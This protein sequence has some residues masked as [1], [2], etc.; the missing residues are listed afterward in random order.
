[1]TDLEDAW[2][3]FLKSGEV[4]LPRNDEIVSSVNENQ[5]P[6]ASELYIS[7][8]TKIL[9]LNT[10]IDLNYVFW[11]IDIIPYNTKTNGV[12]KKQMKFI[13]NSKSELDNIQQKLQSCNYY[14]EYI[15]QHLEQQQGNN[16]LYKDSRKISIGVCNKD[17]TNERSKPKSA[18]YNCFVIILRL[19]YNGVFKEIHIKIFN[20]GKVE[21]PGV[22]N[23][24]V[25][26]QSISIL[27]N[28]LSNI[29][30][31]DIYY[32]K[33]NVET[34]LIN[35]NFHCGF[36]INRPKLFDILKHKHNFNVSY[37]PC[38]YPG[39]QCKYILENNITISFMI[40]RTGSILI[41]G[42]CEEDTIRTVYDIIKVILKDEYYDIHENYD[43]SN[44][45]KQ[46]NKKRKTKTIY[47]S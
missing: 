41:V 16:I 22:Q 45:N 40:F 7:T 44:K 15:I 25:F 19:L 17:L 20:T 43:I 32:D 21:I 1:M 8:K 23:D 26:Y 5:P 47:L 29:T 13:S 12:I 38:S 39:I 2:N 35:S 18:F 14:N 4:N 33:H 27:T 31:T 36:C 37:D 9:Y 3:E 6:S 34:V 28:I 42:K 11:K 10:T 46:K 30:N 24:E